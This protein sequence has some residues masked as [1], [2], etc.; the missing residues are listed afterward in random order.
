M[1]ITPHNRSRFRVALCVFGVAVAYYASG[2]LGVQSSL[3]G[4]RP[5]HG[6]RHL[7]GATLV[8]VLGYLLLDATDFRPELPRLRDVLALVV[9]GGIAPTVVGATMTVGSLRLSGALPADFGTA[10]VVDWSGEA[11]GVIVIAPFLLMVRRLHWP[12]PFRPARWLEAAALFAAMVALLVLTFQREEQLLFLT[13]PFIVWAAWRFHL[14]AAATCVLVATVLATYASL[15]GISAFALH[16]KLSNIFTMQSFAAVTAL[17]ALALSVTVTAR[18][19][20]R[21]HVEEVAIQLAAA[22][23]QLDR[24]LR[25]RPRPDR[26]A[27][28]ELGGEP[29]VTQEKTG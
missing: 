11:L 6:G 26:T 10:W 25:V 16:S 5:A 1:E 19:E 27:G 4:R 23:H 18:N 24:R 21:A 3:A 28:P 20:A 14:A 15:R 7:L 12:R 2:W 8:S 17:T 29:D 22:V 13:S 9:L